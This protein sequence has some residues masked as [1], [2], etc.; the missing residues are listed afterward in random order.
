MGSHQSRLTRVQHADDA[1]RA[2]K[3]PK[4]K[5]LLLG[6]GSS[7]KSTFI[8]QIKLMYQGGFTREDAMT[9]RPYIR[10][11][12]SA[13][14]RDI[15]LFTQTNNPV[16]STTIAKS[17]WWQ[18]EKL[19]RESK[20]S[21]EIVKTL[22]DLW[23]DQSFRMAYIPTL[24]YKREDTLYILEHSKRII[25]DEYIPSHDDIL[26]CRVQTSGTHDTHLETERCIYTLVDVGGQRCERKKWIH[27]FDDVGC[28][29]FFVG[30]NEYDYP[31]E[32]SHTEGNRMTEH[33]NLFE[34]IV[35][36]R[37]FFN[38][39]VVLLLNKH[40][41]FAEKLNTVPL[42]QHFP[43]FK[44]ANNAL[45]AYSFLS[46]QFRVRD[47]YPHNKRLFIHSYCATNGEQHQDFFQYV[48]KM[49]E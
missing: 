38:T 12:L 26:K 31:A 15:I 7:G 27:M 11:S 39:P 3:K 20:V 24:Q 44:G 8:K 9:M 19:T 22:W 41:I 47:Q 21:K 6:S 28:I 48:K 5:I 1:E 29:L 18:L 33:L 49:L 2:S 45:E 30:L 42:S 35:N 16:Y 25:S 37:Y 36:N 32:E 17:A 34:E 4:V 13:I 46:N 14:I 43:E 23:S 40:D 10:H